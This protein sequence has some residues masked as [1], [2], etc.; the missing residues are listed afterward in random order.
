M[1]RE[2]G[3]ELVSDNYVYSKMQ[4]HVSQSKLSNLAR[5]GVRESP[6]FLDIPVTFNDLHDDI[7]N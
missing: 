6:A 2:R 4:Q 5:L 7:A 3:R 1:E